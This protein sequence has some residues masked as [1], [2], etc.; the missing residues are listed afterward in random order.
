MGVTLRRSR[1]APVRRRISV[2]NPQRAGVAAHLRLRG[3]I[4]AAGGISSDGT[5]LF[6]ATGNTEGATSWGG[7]EAVIRLQPGPTFS[8]KTADY[9]ATSNW[10]SLDDNDWDLGGANPVPFD[11][12][13]GTHLI[14]ALGKDGNLYLINRDDLGGE[15]AQ[16]SMTGVSPGDGNGA[17]LFGAPAVYT[18]SQ[19]TYVAF[20]VDN[21]G[22]PSNCPSG[23]GGN[24]GVA[25]ITGGN[26]PTAAMARC[27]DEQN[28]GSPMVTTTDGK[29][30][31]IVW[32]ANNQLYGYDGDTGN[33]V[34]AGGVSSDQMANS[35]HYFNTPIAAKGRIAV[36]TSGQLYIFK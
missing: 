6:F 21:G 9:F 3:G 26:P 7:G 25:K 11:L 34:F 24:M 19:G 5:N 12:P 14:V 8:N 29:S 36:G 10:S 33:K 27:T 16:F 23:G 30:N 4:W 31:F 20:H 35:E 28:L 13:D 18:T 1:S 17:G 15:G 2:A 22:N 32:N